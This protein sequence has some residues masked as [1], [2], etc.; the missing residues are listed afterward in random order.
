VNRWTLLKAMMLAALTVL[1]A[2]ALF[3]GLVLYGEHA[4]LFIKVAVPTV[5]AIGGLTF[6][7]YERMNR[8]TR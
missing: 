3:Y 1:G 8:N 5:M 4:S 7:Y 2:A 6:F